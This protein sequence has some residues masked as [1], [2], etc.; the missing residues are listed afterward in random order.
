MPPPHTQHARLHTTHTHAQADLPNYYGGLPPENPGSRWPKTSLGAL[1][2][3]RR[4]TPEQ[5]KVLMK[6]CFECSGAFQAPGAPKQ[7]VRGGGRGAGAQG[8]C[9][10]RLRA[11]YTLQQ[12]HQQQKHPVW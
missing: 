9:L 6:I 4:L 11:R 2:D 1:R 7:Q 10:F 3:G 12:K 8:A 5:F